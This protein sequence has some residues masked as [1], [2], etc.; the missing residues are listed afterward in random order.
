MMPVKRRGK[1]AAS[2]MRLDK[3]NT[4][5]CS[6]S[7]YAIGI[8]NKIIVTP[9]KGSDIFD[10]GNPIGGDGRDARLLVKIG[11]VRFKFL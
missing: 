8:N 6:G 7:R 5:G 2:E 1:T 3:K 11:V 10:A 4:K 9:G